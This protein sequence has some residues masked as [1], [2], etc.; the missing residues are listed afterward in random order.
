MIDTKTEPTFALHVGISVQ[1]EGFVAL[2]ME[3]VVFDSN[4]AHCN[5][6]LAIHKKAVNWLNWLTI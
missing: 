4:A 5:W 1:F 6:V 2:L 3:F